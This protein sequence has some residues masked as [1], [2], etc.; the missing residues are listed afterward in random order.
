MAAAP[1]QWTGCPPPTVHWVLVVTLCLSLIWG[2]GHGPSHLAGLVPWGKGR[3]A[4]PTPEASVG[5][6]RPPLQSEGAAAANH[7]QL[8]AANRHQLPAAD[9]TRSLGAAAG[10]QTPAQNE[11]AARGGG[12]PPAG[13]AT[14]TVGVGDFAS[15]ELTAPTPALED[16]QSLL[17]G[18]PRSQ[19]AYVVAV[20]GDSYVEGCV[21]WARTMQH[22]CASE[23]LVAIAVNVSAFAVHHLL[24][25]GLRVVLE[26]HA[27]FPDVHYFAKLYAWKREEYAR[28]VFNDC[29]TVVRRPLQHLF[30]EPELTTIVSGTTR[31]PAGVLTVLQPNVSVY[32]RMRQ[33]VHDK[34]WKQKCSLVRGC[35]DYPFFLWW[36]QQPGSPAVHALPPDF[37]R[38]QG[39]S[40]KTRNTTV[41]HF[42]GNLKPWWLVNLCA[43]VHTVPEKD[44]PHYEWCR[45]WIRSAPP[46]LPRRQQRAGHFCQDRAV[47]PPWWPA[48]MAAHQTRQTASGCQQTA[49][50][51]AT[52][53]GEAYGIVCPARPHLQAC[54]A[55]AKSIRQVDPCRRILVVY[56]THHPWREQLTLS[57]LQLSRVKLYDGVKLPEARWSVPWAVWFTPRTFGQYTKILHLPHNAVVQR[58]LDAWFAAPTGPPVVYAPV[59]TSLPAPVLL[60]PRSAG[61]EKTYH[62]FYRCHLHHDGETDRDALWACVRRSLESNGLLGALTTARSIPNATRTDP[63]VMFDALPEPWHFP[64]HCAHPQQ[65]FAMQLFC[66]KWMAPVR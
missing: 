43:Q 2:I 66:E 42:H 56:T 30:Q 28:I 1:T 54:V 47:P 7:H 10:A 23:D 36:Y 46:G 20:F 11:G 50:R 31:H 29:D 59:Q 19:H 12:A 63:V 44:T 64:S 8:P 62:H 13:P 27:T 26:S 35:G 40:H 18:P 16:G 58:P 49:A 21:A 65:L 57:R 53:D 4:H 52:L 25:S 48:F 34:V 32:L 17:S 6:L 3:G 9:R 45:H 38:H 24:R 51:S 60:L 41:L 5:A 22:L 39:R 33:A 61:A 15:L 37:E 14:P 55:L